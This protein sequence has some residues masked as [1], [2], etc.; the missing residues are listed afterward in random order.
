MATE[1]QLNELKAL[2]NDQMNNLTLEMK[3]ISDK[4]IELEAKNATLTQLMAKGNKLEK[5]EMKF[6]NDGDDAIIY[7][8]DFEV[9]AKSQGHEEKDLTKLLSQK[10]RGAAR[11]WFMTDI[12][13]VHKDWNDV[14]RQFISTFSKE[15]RSD[16]LVRLKESRMGSAESL[17]AFALRLKRIVQLS[18]TQLDDA[19]QTAMVYSSLPG[20]AK[21][22]MRFKDGSKWEDL[23]EE[24][25]M[26]QRSNYQERSNFQERE[27][28]NSKFQNSGKGK[29]FPDRKSWEQRDWNPSQNQRSG[30][31][32]QRGPRPKVWGNS[33]Q[34]GG[35]EQREWKHTERPR[36]NFEKNYA[37]KIDEKEKKPDTRQSH[38]SEEGKEENASE[39]GEVQRGEFEPI[40]AEEKARLTEVVK[41]AI[42]AVYKKE[43]NKSSKLPKII[44]TFGTKKLITLLDTGSEITIINEKTVQKLG[45]NTQKVDI[46]LRGIGQAKINRKT[47]LTIKM[48]KSTLKINPLVAKIGSVDLIIGTNDLKKMKVVIDVDK[49]TVKNKRSNVIEDYEKSEA[50]SIRIKKDESFKDGDICMLIE[51]VA[52]HNV[53]MVYHQKEDGIRGLIS[54]IPCNQSSGFLGNGEVMFL[55]DNKKQFSF[56][57]ES[58]PLKVNTGN[59]KV[60]VNRNLPEQVSFFVKSNV[61]IPPLTNKYVD[62]GSSI[63]EESRQA[64]LLESVVN[65]C[66]E[67]LCAPNGLVYPKTNSIIISN[68]SKK[69]VILPAFTV[70]GI[71]TKSPG[72]RSDANQGIG[73]ANRQEAWEEFE[74]A[75]DLDEGQKS[76][77]NALLYKYSNVFS[78]HKK[79]VG[80]IEGH[81]HSIEVEDNKPIKLNAHRTSMKQ[82]EIISGEIKELLN[83]G[84][85]EKSR[86]PY[87]APVIVVPK[88]D[89]GYRLVI[90]YRRLNKITKKDSYPIPRISDNLDS[91][92]NA[93]F[94]STM[95]LNSGF[96][97]LK[98]NP[99]DKEKTAF[100][101]G[102]GLYQW[103][104]MPMG[105]STGRAPSREQWTQF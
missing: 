78:I 42:E 6:Y 79:D 41:E 47:E 16:F 40:K 48:L 73:R 38:F 18:P 27:Y 65:E 96:Y 19:Q 105:L 9:T 88:K 97:N 89:G 13:D 55:K 5:F 60:K 84:L 86:S 45:L 70:V 34:S 57:I 69:E 56:Y 59:K 99:K 102:Q 103:V 7:V 26:V 72:Q 17:V 52:G 63:N 75:D 14:K 31:Y 21:R 25:K 4:N 46:L 81:E 51:K 22:K 66:Q 43:E 94:F 83:A 36:Q 74:F 11:T 24:L 100:T 33:S 82:R 20:W 15:A 87:S 53:A 8:N 85:I 95:D 68:F 2:F 32:D 1:E 77:I 67:G 44:S 12:G 3:R 62:V 37:Q 92:S 90:D 10:L 98:M 58:V 71:A 93:K 64:Y 30:N 76:K 101:T 91:I 49:G 61:T 23:L 50:G 39:N 54:D 35:R 28:S 80:M 104:R 29:M